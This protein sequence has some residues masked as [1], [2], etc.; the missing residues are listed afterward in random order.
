MRTATQVIAGDR[1]ISE[2]HSLSRYF[3]ESY[4]C[5]RSNALDR[6]TPIG[7]LINGYLQGQ[8]QLDDH[9]IHLLFSAN[10]WEIAQRVEDD[11]N[12]GTTVIV[13]RYSYSGAVYSAAKANPNLP[14]EWA[15]QPEIG[16]PC[17]DVCLFL[18][19]SPEDA[20]KRGGFGVERYENAAMQARVRELFHTLFDL[21]SGN[22]QI[23]DAGRS[24]DQ[25]SQDIGQIV[26]ECMNHL[27]GIGPLRKLGPLTAGS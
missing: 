3:I 20:A 4:K 18:R 2:I 25:V 19:V 23:I 7:Q 5:I 26:A 6:T 24:A 1:K 14:L 17:P 15:W 16:L 22:V 9:S 10:R 27:G 21:Q 8:S 13:D 12:N 11:I